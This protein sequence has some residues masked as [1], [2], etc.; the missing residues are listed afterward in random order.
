MVSRGS[1]DLLKGSTPCTFIDRNH[2]FAD[3]GPHPSPE[4]RSGWFGSGAG[5]RSRRRTR[6][7]ARER[8]L[9]LARTPAG[10]LRLGR[11]GRG[12]GDEVVARRTRR[13]SSGGRD[14]L[15]RRIGRDGAG[16]R[17]ASVSRGR[18]LSSPRLG[19]A[20]G[21]GSDP[22]PGGSPT[23]HVRRTSALR[24]SCWN[25]PRERSIVSLAG[26]RWRFS[27]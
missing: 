12:L 20:G 1:G 16:C 4:A 6:L 11:M 17:G 3:G 9:V 22:G 19:R 23:W 5:E 13:R 8:G 18:G 21:I 27:R 2:D 14:P 7:S 26:H 15:P 24:R 10:R 25:R